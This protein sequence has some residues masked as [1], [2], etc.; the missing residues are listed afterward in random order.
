MAPPD[1]IDDSEHEAQPSLGRREMLRFGVVAG[2]AAGCAQTESSRFRHGVASADPMANSIIVWTRLA[3]ASD[4]EALRLL[5]ASD[6][7]LSQDVRVIDVVARAEVDHTVSVAVDGLLP[8]AY[9]L[10]RF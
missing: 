3:E 4:G 5:V 7:D 1:D 10:L 2:V 6:E 9:Y 8:D